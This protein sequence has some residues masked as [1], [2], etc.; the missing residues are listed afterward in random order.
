ME[1]PLLERRGGSITYSL[2]YVVQL[3][4]KMNFLQQHLHAN[5]LVFC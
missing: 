2:L 3:I 4:V 1:I 5:T